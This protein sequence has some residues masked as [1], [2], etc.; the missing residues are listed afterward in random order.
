MKLESQVKEN[1][2]KKSSGVGK[3]PV[4][5]ADGA[6]FRYLLLVWFFVHHRNIPAI[7]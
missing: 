5:L 7:Y 6:W 3:L 2:Y 4:C 1:I